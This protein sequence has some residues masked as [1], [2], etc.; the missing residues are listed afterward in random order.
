MA[1]ADVKES[2]DDDQRRL[3]EEFAAVTGT[4]TS[5]AEY[6][7]REK[8][9]QIE[10][11]LNVY[12]DGGDPTPQIDLDSHSMSP[13][14]SSGN[15]SPDLVVTYDSGAPADSNLGNQTCSLMLK[16][17]TW[18]IDGLDNK[19]ITERT[20]TVC[21]IIKRESPDVVY[22]QEVIVET[23]AYIETMC[24]PTYIAIPA[25]SEQYFTTILLRKSRI[26]LLAHKIIEF[27][28]TKMYRNLL[29]VKAR[30]RDIDLLLMTSHMESMKNHSHERKT[31]LTTVLKHMSEADAATAVI[32]GGDTNLRDYEITQIGG[33]PDSIGDVW[34]MCG[35]PEDAQFSWDITKNDNLDMPFK[36]KC[37]FDRLF[38]RQ[39]CSSKLLPQMFMFVGT[40]RLPCG[41]FASDHWGILCEFKI[42]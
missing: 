4:D 11:A 18:N 5:L 33:L 35:S 37:R 15:S 16:L 7:L 29:T 36:P 10:E 21:S 31:Q 20:K 2:V 24:S 14:G 25:N 19:N 27:P 9:W 13:S 8:N 40:E 41:R 17:L 39:G 6:Y 1:A 22:L 42:V 26:S 32:F 38:L 28:T 12:F 34:Q 3:C 30:F 23:F